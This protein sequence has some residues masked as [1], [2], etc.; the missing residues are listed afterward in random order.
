[1][2]SFVELYGLRGSLVNNHNAIGLMLEQQ[3]VARLS[4]APPPRILMDIIDLAMLILGF[5]F[6]WYEIKKE[7]PVQQ[8]C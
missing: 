1:V 3:V 2:G 8:T 7:K 4:V 5:L 6:Q